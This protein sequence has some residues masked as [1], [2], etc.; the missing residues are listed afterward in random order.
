MGQD[1][2]ARMVETYCKQH[3]LSLRE[4]GEMVG[5]TAS[6]LSRLLRGENTPTVY[7]LKAIHDATGIPLLSMVYALVDMEPEND[8]KAAQFFAL[9]GALTQRQQQALIELLEALAA[10]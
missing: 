5:R 7:T 9:F 2:F 3:G 4:F 10:G 8:P 1:E 6:A